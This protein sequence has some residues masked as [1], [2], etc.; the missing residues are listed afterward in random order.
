MS[1]R[2]RYRTYSITFDMEGR[3]EGDFG[4]FRRDLDRL[5]ESHPGS[6]L[7]ANAETDGWPCVAV[8]EPTVI[9]P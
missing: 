4:D 3:S 2:G 6:L 5:E 8:K 9:Q 1:E 7:V